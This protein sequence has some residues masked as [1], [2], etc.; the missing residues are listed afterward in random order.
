MRYYGGESSYVVVLAKG[1]ELMDC[2]R[3]FVKDSG[4]STAWLQGLG[5]ALEVEVGYYEL[6]NQK[7]QWQTLSGPLEITALAGNIVHKE[8]EAVF[9][10]HGTF[11][12][13]DY[14]CMGG[15]VKRLVVAATCEIFVQKI[16]HALT[17]Q[18]D[19]SVGLELL[20]P[21]AE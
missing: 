16:N 5:A 18:R 21:A 13:K 6:E 14:S 2:L 7:Y 9:H 10:I 17:R 4:V 3:Q 20:Q 1:E 19:P 8:G 15:H 11:G 12:G